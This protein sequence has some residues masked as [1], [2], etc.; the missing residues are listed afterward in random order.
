L[1]KEAID[2]VFTAGDQMEHLAK[3]LDPAMSAGHAVNTS[4]L[5]VMVLKAVQ[6][7]DVVVIKGSAGS[8]TGIIV[9]AFL[10]LNQT[11]AV[12]GD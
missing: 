3:A 6:P 1:E 4:L 8:K 11:R 12:S 5:K 2:L 10:D 7:G 9:Q